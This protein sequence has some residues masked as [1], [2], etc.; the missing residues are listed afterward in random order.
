MRDYGDWIRRPDD[1]SDDGIGMA[2]F[3]ASILV[4]AFTIYVLCN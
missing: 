1:F 4:V 2:L 3:L